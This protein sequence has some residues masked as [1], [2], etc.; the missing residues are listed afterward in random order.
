METK[1]EIM[2][3]LFIYFS[4]RQSTTL[5]QFIIMS[6]DMNHKTNSNVFWY[7]L[8]SKQC[9]PFT[10]ITSKT[11]LFGFYL[12][13]PQFLNSM[14]NAQPL[15]LLVRVLTAALKSTPGSKVLHFV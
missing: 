8:T 14:R 1:Q 4:A 10:V 3:V 7:S 12:S 2:Y 13:L 5:S 11:S 15:F 6:I 9:S